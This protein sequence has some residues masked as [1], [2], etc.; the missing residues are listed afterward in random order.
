MVKDGGERGLLFELD[1]SIRQ[2]RADHGD[3]ATAISL[4]GVYHNLLR[5]AGI[6]LAH[7]IF[8]KWPDITP[9]IISRN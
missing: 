2:L 9:S 7:C 6:V 1:T 3:N 4:T 8:S 5:K